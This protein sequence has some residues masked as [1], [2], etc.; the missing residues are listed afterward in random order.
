ML[1]LY[2]RPKH[3]RLNYKTLR[4]K[5]KGKLHDIGFGNDIWS[6]ILKAKAKDKLVFFHKKYI[7]LY[8]KRYQQ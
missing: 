8:V 2:Q 4:R 6:I 3:K 1:K 7:L 5:L